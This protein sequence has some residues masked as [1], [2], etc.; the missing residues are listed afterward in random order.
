MNDYVYKM[1]VTVPV[2]DDDFDLNGKQINIQYDG[3][4]ANSPRAAKGIKSVGRSAETYT[5]MGPYQCLETT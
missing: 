3:I 4:Q 2:R 1:T 5:A